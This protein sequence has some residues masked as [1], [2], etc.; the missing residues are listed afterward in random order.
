MT[1][2]D[3]QCPECG[4][5]DGLEVNK[6]VDGNDVVESGVYCPDC[7]TEFGEDTVLQW[8]DL[9][10]PLWL[11]EEVRLD[12]WRLWRTLWRSENLYDGDYGSI[13]DNRDMKCQVFF[14]WFKITEDGDVE[15][16]YDE[17]RGEKL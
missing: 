13:P 6:A 3:T 4:W 12:D 2:V 11:H 5:M 9:E 7:E 10:F 14:V 17:K 16:P 1:D 8:D 15:G